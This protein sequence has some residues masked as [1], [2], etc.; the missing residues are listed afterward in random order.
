VRHKVKTR[1][2]SRRTGQRKALLKS[3]V[4]NLLINERISTTVAKAKEASRFMDKL[5]TLGKKNDIPARR[6][7]LVILDDRTLV[8]AL[9]D[10]T[11]PRF[12]KRAGGYTRILRTSYR[13]GDGAEMAI[14][15]LVERKPKP[16]PEPKGKKKKKKEATP[17]ETAQ[18]EAETAEAKT[19]EEPI[20]KMEET[21]AKKT[22]RI[23]HKK[24]KKKFG[25][26]RKFFQTRR[27]VEGK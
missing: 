16:K 8:K 17:E 18:V 3:L 7:A 15:E 11:A 9:F 24:D 27:Q 21:E 22:K 14:L 10:E 25:G 5:I 23:D 13:A 12:A 19:A 6:K 4:R 2:L 20:K 1:T 26:F